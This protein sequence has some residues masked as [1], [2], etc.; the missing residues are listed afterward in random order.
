VAARFHFTA[1]HARALQFDEHKRV[2]FEPLEE[3]APQ[4]QQ[5]HPLPDAIEVDLW[6]KDNTTPLSLSLSNGD[7]VPRSV[8]IARR[9]ADTDPPVVISITNLCAQR[10]SAGADDREFAAY[11]DLMEQP[12]APRHRLVPRAAPAPAE[13]AKADCAGVATVEF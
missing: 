11:Y 5:E 3:L 6:R 1:G 12:P 13:G 4:L 9:T 10:G 8:V 2:S 7:G